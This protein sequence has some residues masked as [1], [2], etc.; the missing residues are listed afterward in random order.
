ME[1]RVRGAADA[2]L[3]R[4]VQR[5]RFERDLQEVLKDAQVRPPALRAMQ[6]DP[7][8]PVAKA[9][10]ASRVLASLPLVRLPRPEGP[11]RDSLIER[12]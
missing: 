10:T 2:S 4:L 9:I 8:A 7:A 11:V 3:N 1:L 12:D 6:S 5:P